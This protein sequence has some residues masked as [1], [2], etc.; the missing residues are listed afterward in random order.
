[1]AFARAGARQ[2][3]MGITKNLEDATPAIKERW[4][5]FTDEFNV[6]ELELLVKFVTS[7]KARPS[8]EDPGRRPEGLGAVQAM[9]QKPA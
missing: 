2:V 3:L 8:R 9:A 4:S 7:R 1:M 6:K 5:S